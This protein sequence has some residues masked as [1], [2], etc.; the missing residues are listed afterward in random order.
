MITIMNWIF[1]TKLG[2]IIFIGV[3][4]LLFGLLVKLVWHGMELA[5]LVAGALAF[6]IFDA[7]RDKSIKWF[8]L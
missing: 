3:S 6:A 4:V 2:H 1:G 5:F 8:K 7:I